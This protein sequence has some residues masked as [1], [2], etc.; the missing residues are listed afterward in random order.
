MILKN[1]YE[2]DSFTID[3]LKNI[4]EFECEIDNE[5]IKFIK[6]YFKDAWS[7]VYFIDDQNKY[8][9]KI[10]IKYNELNVIE[11]EVFILQKLQI[12]HQYFP[13]LVCFS[14]KF[15]VLSWV[16]EEINKQNIPKNVMNQ[17]QDICHIL[18][19]N[20]IT[21]NDIKQS[22]ILVG[23]KKNIFLIDFGWAKYKGNLHC[24]MGFSNKGVNSNKKINDFEE[25]KK[26]INKIIK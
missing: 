19:I 3:E 4:H 2:I 5:K 8:F 12:Y 26:I 1:I 17:L 25:I 24:G 7:S 16:G 23:N 20:D 21:H 14:K 13:K 9:L 15:I 22:Q 18:N 10:P 11:R 6:K